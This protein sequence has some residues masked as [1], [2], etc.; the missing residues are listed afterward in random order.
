M[1]IHCQSVFS[2]FRRF[3]GQMF[4][5][6]K[7][8]LR[9]CMIMSGYRSRMVVECY[10]EAN[11]EESQRK[12]DFRYRVFFSMRITI[13]YI[14]GPS[15]T[16]SIPKIMS[17]ASKLKEYNQINFFTILRNFENLG[18]FYFQKNILIVRKSWD[19]LIFSKNLQLWRAVTFFLLNRFQ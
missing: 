5:L 18:Q 3:Q 9:R 14:K 12:S 16:C 7:I 19:F 2:D 1:F 11:S 6:S 13:W 4:G 15:L 10:K 17:K 8:N